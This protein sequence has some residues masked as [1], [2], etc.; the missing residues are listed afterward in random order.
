MDTILGVGERVG[1]DAAGLREALERR[2]YRRQVDDGIRWSQEIGV[3]AVPTFVFDER[4]G[5]AGAQ[6]YAVFQA[7]MEKLGA[8]PRV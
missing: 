5:F 2:S 1:V 3:T 7:V 6:E 8:T 4:Y